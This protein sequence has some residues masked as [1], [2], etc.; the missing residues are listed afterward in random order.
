[1][2][3][4]EHRPHH[5]KFGHVEAAGF[6][7]S[8]SSCDEAEAEG[9]QEQEQ[10]QENGRRASQASGGS[11]R[12]VEDPA[13]REA[14]RMEQQDARRRRVHED[15]RYFFRRP[16][17][18][19]YFRGNVLV[20]SED[21]RSSHR[22]E[23][24]FDLVFV[25]LIAVLAQEAVH[26]HNGYAIVR[27]VITY[28][29]A[30]MVWNYM[31]EVFNSFFVDDMPQRCLILVVMCCL[32]VYGNNATAVEKEHAAGGGARET[33]IGAYLVA[34]GV[35]MLTGVFY[36]VFVCQYRAQL[37]AL[38]LNWVV[39]MAL[40]IGAIFVSVKGA[41]AMAAVALAL[42]YCG[43]L[44]FFSPAFKR[45]LRL[46]YSSAVA[47]EHEVERFSDFVTL[48][49][50]EFLYSVVS[51]NPAGHGMHTGVART[52]FT[53]FI[54]FAIHGM[55]CNGAGSRTVTHGLRKS[56][57]RALLWFTFHL[58]FVSALTLCGDSTAE[59]ISETEVPQGVRWI[60]SAS[61]AIAMVSVTLIAYTEC[62]HDEP[63]VLWFPKMVR[64]A[65]RVVAALVV[66]FLPLASQEQINSTA[67]LGIAAALT[68]AAW[69]FQELGSLDGPNAPWYT[70]HESVDEQDRREWKGRPTFVEPG[71]WKL[72]SRSQR[73]AVPTFSRSDNVP[74]Q[75][76]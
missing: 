24:F 73:G 42:E 50:G 9:L 36:S 38:A 8:P 58:P 2:P 63:G 76:P 34:G 7:E 71:A 16:R 30:W 41:I 23:L 67:L 51:G 17:A 52:I 55:Y 29:A 20:R 43:W 53:V 35:I 26:E 44:Y 62:D 60:F 56:M 13:L 27:Y 59:L 65:P 57:A 46:R 69:I 37:R 12:A 72:D 48:V 21:E 11:K 4:E 25:G 66:L 45:L 10:E 1:M 6:D 5:M 54:A 33:A 3:A 15:R 19:Q 31:R 39:A 14:R 22:L 75:D 32:V 74:Q 68:M 40:W 70:G 28:M 47:I 49:H 61:Y 64:V 18:L